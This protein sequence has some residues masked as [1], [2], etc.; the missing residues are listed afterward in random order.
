[1]P[2]LPGFPLGS[3]LP[4]QS[5]RRDFPRP[6]CVFE[7]VLDRLL[8]KDAPKI[9]QGAC[10]RRWKGYPST[11]VTSNAGEVHLRDERDPVPSLEPLG[12]QQF[13]VS[14]PDSVPPSEARGAPVGCD[15][16][17]PQNSGHHPLLPGTRHAS[18]SGRPEARSGSMSRTETSTE[19]ARH[20]S[21]GHNLTSGDKTKSI[22]SAGCN[23]RVEV[24]HF[25]MSFHALSK[26]EERSSGCDDG[27]THFQSRAQN[28][29]SSWKGTP[30]GRGLLDV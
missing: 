17:R 8:L 16:A 29:A 25:T 10:G 2:R 27:H 30:R 20:W 9:E 19:S 26:R 4:P 23:L 3:E 14:L 18:L 11:V 12:H 15:P 6:Q 13:D 1:M 5:G 28:C 22:R 7:C 24:E 21:Q